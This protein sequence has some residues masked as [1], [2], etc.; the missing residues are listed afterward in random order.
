VI[1]VD[2]S[3][4]LQW[5]LPEAGT[6]AALSLLGRPDLIAPDILL[7]ESANVLAK[8]VRSK[9]LTLEEALAGLKIIRDAVPT[10]T[11]SAELAGESLRLAVELVHPAYD[12]CFLACA[13]AADCS[14]ATRDQPFINRLVAHGHAHRLHFGATAQ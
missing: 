10:L 9:E 11:S 14:F 2:S 5:V 4:A 1:A 7:V 3:I 8:K 13:I 6:D 12:C